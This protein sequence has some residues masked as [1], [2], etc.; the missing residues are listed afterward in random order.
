[1]EGVTSV[2][3]QAF[4]E[5]GRQVAHETGT[6]SMRRL[7]LLVLLASLGSTAG[8]SKRV[9]VAQL[10]QALITAHA[11]HKPDADIARQIGGLELSERLTEVTLE[12]LTGYV[13]A[14]SQAALA[15][16]L[17]AD[18]S[19]FLDPPANELPSTAAPDE[20][21]QQ[22]MIEAARSYVAKHLLQLPNLFAT[23]TTNR[24]DDSPYDVKKSGWP[25]RA[26]LHLVN[27][28][29]RESSI[30]DE[31]TNQS[32]SA[33]S[34]YFQEQS[35]LISGGEFGSTLSMILSDT[36]NGKVAWSH[37]E[38][39]PTGQVAVFH[40]SVPGSASHFELINSLQRQASI[41]ATALPTIGS[42]QGSGIN[43]KSSSSSNTATIVTRTGYH[44]ALWVDPVT[45]TI[46]RATMDA[47]TKGSVQF[48]RAAIMVQYG[49]VKI[50]D[51][52]FICPVRSLALSI[53]ASGVNLDP[54]TRMPGDAPSV[55][56]NE[57]GFTGY[58]RFATTTRI[59]RDT[60]AP[61]QRQDSG[62]QSGRL[63]VDQVEGGQQAD[64]RKTVSTARAFPRF[65]QCVIVS[66]H[67]VQG[68][69]WVLPPY[70][71]LEPA[72]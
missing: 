41:E 51:S 8:A 49:P 4:H 32:T 29:R 47:D 10:E 54:L 22:R 67:C 12:R 70:L 40:Y 42:R 38:Q 57:S 36:V 60:E 53:A 5:H 44:G 56:L 71:Q 48:K 59:V 39:T 64:G 26:G 58:H 15:L 65:R 6:V 21:T 14:G 35:G 72:P 55:W 23:R 13:D 69:S 2:H 1:M 27:T 33:S 46:L 25:V 28:S 62:A 34:A 3:P 18:Q 16:Q 11:A 61:P 45:G 19:A 37:W 63:Q 30:F 66:L 43:M 31:R 17:L 68:L 9:T 7:I 50:G 52:E 24:Y 20:A